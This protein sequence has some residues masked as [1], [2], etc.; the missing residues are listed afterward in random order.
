MNW[1]QN[2]TQEGASHSLSICDCIIIVCQ[3][4]QW[5]TALQYL[6]TRLA[7]ARAHTPLNSHLA[8]SLSRSLSLSFAPSTVSISLLGCTPMLAFPRIISSKQMHFRVHCSLNLGQLVHRC[9]QTNLL[10]RLNEVSRWSL[11]TLQLH[12]W[13]QKFDQLEPCETGFHHCE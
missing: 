5:Y 9:L 11:E 4:W 6:H 8:L 10:L 7:R 2:S 12:E 3:Y 13:C 1:F